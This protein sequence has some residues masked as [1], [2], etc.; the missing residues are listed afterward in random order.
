MQSVPS[1][2]LQCFDINLLLPVVGT[3]GLRLFF[4]LVG[5]LD[6]LCKLSSSICFCSTRLLFLIFFVNFLKVLFISFLTF[7]LLKMKAV[8]IN[9]NTP[10]GTGT[11]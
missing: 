10:K 2:L 7:V 9:F 5:I 4:V 8:E 3:L 1:S 6:L 11:Y